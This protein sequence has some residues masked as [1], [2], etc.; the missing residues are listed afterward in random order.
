MDGRLFTIEYLDTLIGQMKAQVWYGE[1][2][3][4]VTEVKEYP[5]GA[6]VIEGVVAA[7]DLTE[8]VETLIPKAEEWGREIGCTMAL[9]QS[10]PGWARQ[11]KQYGYETHQVSITKEL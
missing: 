11:L 10:R 2:S 5:S 1:R 4:I 8:I 3:A 6:R 9:I 7:G